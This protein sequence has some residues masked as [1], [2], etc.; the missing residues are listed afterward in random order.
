MHAREGLDCIHIE[1][2]K[3]KKLTSLYSYRADVVLM[4]NRGLRRL[5]VSS[6]QTSLDG[7]MHGFLCYHFTYYWTG[8]HRWNKSAQSWFGRWVHILPF[9]VLTEFEANKPN[10]LLNSP[11]SY[12]LAF[13]NALKDVV[14][15]IPNGPRKETTDDVVSAR[16][17][18]NLHLSGINHWISSI[19]LL[20]CLRR[21]VRR[22]L[23]QSTNIGGCTFESN[24]FSRRNCYKMLS[25]ATKNY[26]ECPLQRKTKQISLS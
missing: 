9:S 18:T 7:L 1:N 22:E 20:L 4:L 23:V 15:T 10:S 25:G 19:G 6:E 11:F 13:N 26:P 21:S 3:R 17:F 12:S 16:I 2:Q 8:Q 14:K 5:T 24:D